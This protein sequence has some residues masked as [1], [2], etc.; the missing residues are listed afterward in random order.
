ME[1]KQYTSDDFML[2]YAL[3]QHESVMRYITGNALNEDETARKFDKVMRYN[4]NN[5]TTGHYR[6]YFEGKYIGYG[7]ITIS[8][9]E[10]E[11]GYMLLPAYIGRGL[12]KKLLATLIDYAKKEDTVYVIFAIIQSE[13]DISRNL[14]KSFGFQTVAV[15]EENGARCERLEL[16]N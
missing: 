3:T 8:N 2:Y 16:A 5:R 7:K 12:G 14:L 10:I 1:L 13:N 15:Y 11:V 4:E 9:K 6:V